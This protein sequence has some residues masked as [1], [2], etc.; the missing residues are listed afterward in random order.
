[1]IYITFD[2]CS[3]IYNN[4]LVILGTL[5]DSWFLSSVHSQSLK[6]YTTMHYILLQATTKYL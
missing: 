2:K 3:P 1:M 4:M 6:H 5:I